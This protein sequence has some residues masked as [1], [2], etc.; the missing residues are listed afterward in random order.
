MRTRIQSLST[1]FSWFYISTE[2]FAL[3]YLTLESSHGLVV[4]AGKKRLRIITSDLCRYF[5]LILYKKP[6]YPLTQRGFHQL[7]DLRIVRELRKFC[8]QSLVIIMHPLC[9]NGQL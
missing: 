6:L 1:F 2:F 5:L 7:I 4:L 8:K 3:K 9:L